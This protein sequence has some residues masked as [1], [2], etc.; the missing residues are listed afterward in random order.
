MQGDKK[1]STMDDK[2]M[3]L[4]QLMISK[5]REVFEDKLDNMSDK[6]EEVVQNQKHTNTS[7]QGL[8]VE[9]EKN[10]QAHINIISKQDEEKK[11]TDDMCKKVTDLE[12]LWEVKKDKF[13]KIESDID[14]AKKKNIKFWLTI[15][16]NWI[17]IAVFFFPWVAFFL[18][19]F[20]FAFSPA[21]QMKVV[22]VL[23]NLL[24]K[25]I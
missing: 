7:I 21:F 15:S 19:L 2:D 20:L 5:I 12:K 24:S 8:L 13:E 9:A 18:F 10:K 1:H 3:Q 25:G 11:R 4:V 23:A 6:M 22:E 16:E 14:C 17:R